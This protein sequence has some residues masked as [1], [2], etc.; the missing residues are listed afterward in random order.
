MRDGTVG[1]RHFLCVRRCEVQRSV[2]QHAQHA[3]RWTDGSWHPGNSL[4]DRRCVCVDT[5]RCKPGTVGHHRR[6]HRRVRVDNR[7]DRVLQ[8]A[9]CVRYLSA[10]SPYSSHDPAPSDGSDW[11]TVCARREHPYWND[12]DRRRSISVKT[13]RRGV[14]RLVAAAFLVAGASSTAC[15]GGALRSRALPASASPRRSFTD[16]GG[17]HPP[18]SRRLSGGRA[19][20]EVQVRAAACW[21]KRADRGHGSSRGSLRFADGAQPGGGAGAARV[22]A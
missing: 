15:G 4:S 21:R 10:C 18:R 17:N 9:R 3:S 14:L 22:V 19:L 1:T 16:F 12:A 20:A 7:R 2:R 5:G 6:A 8:L 13:D 11:V